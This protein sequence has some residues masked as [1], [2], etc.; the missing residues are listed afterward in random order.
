MT[1]IGEFWG[2]LSK[3]KSIASPKQTLQSKKRNPFMMRMMHDSD[4]ED[5]DF[6]TE[7]SPPLREMIRDEEEM[8]RRR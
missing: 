7:N 6:D 5:D 3:M 1:E 8:E 2:Y 4:D